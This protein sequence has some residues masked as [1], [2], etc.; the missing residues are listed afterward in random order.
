VSTRDEVISGGRELDSLLATLPSNIHANILRSALSAGAKV[1]KKEVLSLIPKDTGRLASTVR[2]TS[3]VQGR[4]G[5]VSA[6]VKAGNSKVTYAESVEFGT[7]EHSIIAGIGHSL[8]VNGRE[9]KAVL[10]PG[11]KKKPFMRPAA[12]RGH[13]AAVKAVEAKIRQR[14]TK[15][16]VS[17]PDAVQEDSE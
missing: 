6:S 17:V 10:H 15:A 7:R 2:V 5:I 16:G 4:K 13:D 12:A 11:A 3:R 8:N 9:Y 1:F 14:L